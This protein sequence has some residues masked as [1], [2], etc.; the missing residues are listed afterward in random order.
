MAVWLYWLTLFPVHRGLLCSVAEV[1]GYPRCLPFSNLTTISAQSCSLTSA[2]S[3]SLTSA[4][5]CSRTSAQACS[6]NSHS[7]VLHG[8]VGVG[9]S[10][11]PS[12]LVQDR[13][14]AVPSIP[15]QTKSFHQNAAKFLLQHPK[16]HSNTERKKPQDAVRHRVMQL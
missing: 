5:A 13:S 11:I 16:I 14:H 12:E 7:L 9:S 10:I 2:Q 8:E 4:Q 1:A 3:C 6:L 15:P